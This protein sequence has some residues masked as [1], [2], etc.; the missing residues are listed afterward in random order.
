ML[1]GYCVVKS[2]LSIGVFHIFAKVESLAVASVKE[3]SRV[4][5]SVTNPLEKNPKEP[6]ESA[7]KTLST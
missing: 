1:Q 7:G 4:E 5:G 3:L 6:P 2:A